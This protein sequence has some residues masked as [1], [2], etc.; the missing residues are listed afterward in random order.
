MDSFD[1]VLLMEEIPKYIEIWKVTRD[2]YR[3]E[4]GNN[5]AR[6][7]IY[8][9]VYTKFREMSNTGKTAISESFPF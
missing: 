6:I 7:K 3:D 9:Q 1:I 4:N 8:E 2:N 5:L